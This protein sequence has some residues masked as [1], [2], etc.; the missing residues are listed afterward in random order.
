MNDFIANLY[1]LWG[2]SYLGDF[3]NDM[4]Q[5]GFYIPIFIVMLASVITVA[6]IYYYV[7]NHPRVNRWYHWLF[8]NIGT[9]LV[10]FAAA[11]AIASDK[12]Y[13]FF[14]QQGMAASYDWINYFVLAWMAFLWAFVFFFL[15]SFV[16]KWGSRNCKHTPFI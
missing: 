15:F 1:E 5:N 11:W 6:A 4:Y 8:F 9:A 14:A 7:V 13:S 3:S 16:I 2:A 12:V 10:N